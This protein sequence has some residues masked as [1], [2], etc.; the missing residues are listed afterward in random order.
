MLWTPVR[1]QPCLREFSS[2]CRL[3]SIYRYMRTTT[4]ALLKVEV[5]SNGNV[6][7]IA[8]TGKRSESVYTE[9]LIKRCLATASGPLYAVMH[10]NHDPNYK[11]AVRSGQVEL[12]RTSS[13]SDA[14][15]FR[16]GSSS[17]LLYI[18]LKSKSTGQ[19]MES[20]EEGQVQLA[21]GSSNSDRKTWLK[22]K[23]CN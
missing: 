18:T 14:H 21:V 4:Q 20:S 6:S 13:T 12:E 15:R 23:Y 10:W 19:L 17:N 5:Y 8:F 1:N 7:G 9:F 11:L 2:K 3:R 16:L 22:M